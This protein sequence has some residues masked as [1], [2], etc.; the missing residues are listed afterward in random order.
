MGAYLSFMLRDNPPAPVEWVGVNAVAGGE[1]PRAVMLVPAGGAGVAARGGGVATAGSAL[2]PSAAFSKPGIGGGGV[3]FGG[4]DDDP[5]AGAGATPAPLPWR[6]AV[7]DLSG[8]SSG[9]P[10]S[11]S[12]GSG[13]T[14]EGGFLRRAVA[15]LAARFPPG[16]AA[17]AATSAV[18]FMAANA[19]LPWVLPR[20]VPGWE[21][22]TPATQRKF[23]F[24]V[25]S[26]AHHLVAAPWSTGILVAEARAHAAG[27]HFNY[28]A[29]LRLG[30]FTTGYFVADFLG[31][32]R[33]AVSSPDFLFHHVAALFII[34]RG[35]RPQL[36]R[37]I[38]HFMI[39]EWST[40]LLDVMWVMRQLGAVGTPSYNAIALAFFAAFT[41][42]RIINLPLMAVAAFTKFHGSVDGALGRFKWVIPAVVALQFHWWFKILAQITPLLRALLPAALG[43]LAPAAAAAAAASSGP[44]AATIV[45]ATAVAA[46]GDAVTA[47][48]F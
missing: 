23:V 2:S 14:Q 36:A 35:V 4:G 32:L 43:G 6:G 31:T 24:Y 8:S 44:T 37:F 40:I 10:S 29:S 48:T 20:V 13:N 16:F 47:A 7:A 34:W 41:V 9:D 28:L 22:L 45:A 12:S 5:G 26:C 17:A 18:G 25:S 11:S 42:T 21:R 1:P 15:K 27:R 46:A 19:A 33:E 39:C 30:A 38:P 3:A